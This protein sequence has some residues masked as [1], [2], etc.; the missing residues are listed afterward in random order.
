MMKGVFLTG[1]GTGVGKT[2]VAALLVKALRDEGVNAGYFKAALS[3]LEDGPSDAARV[4]RRAGLPEPPEFFVP[5]AFGPAVS[6]HLAARWAGR[7]IE[8]PQ[9]EAAHQRVAARYDFI[10]AEGSGGIVCPLRL[11][12]DQLMLVDVVRALGYPAVVISPAGLGAINASV[13]TAHY[14]RAQG[15]RV[16]GAVLNGFEPGNLMHEDNA[17]AIERLAALPILARVEREAKS[18]ALDDFFKHSENF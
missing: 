4:C 13:L 5:Y 11:E 1:T 9:I 10:V 14:A 18:M 7:P 15:L 6:P 17:R 12:G 16:L 8:L 3:G 2:Y